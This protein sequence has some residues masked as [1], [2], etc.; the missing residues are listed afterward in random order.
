[1]SEI[2]TFQPQLPS[3]KNAEGQVQTP[4]PGNAPGP[5]GQSGSEIRAFL[6]G[7]G[8]SAVADGGFHILMVLCGLSIF[9]IVALIAIVLMYRSGLA[10]KR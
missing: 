1:M 9:G 10:H 6:R 2:R 7:R 4:Q 3:Q 5:G 8:N